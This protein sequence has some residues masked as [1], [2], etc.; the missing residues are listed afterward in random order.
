MYSDHHTN[1]WLVLLVVALFIIVGPN[2]GAWF[3]VPL[4]LCAEV[5]RFIIAYIF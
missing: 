3:V 2:L 5:V 1:G 4:M